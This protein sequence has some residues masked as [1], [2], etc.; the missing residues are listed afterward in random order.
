MSQTSL[1]GCRRGLVRPCHGRSRA[2]D[3]APP[4][5]ARGHGEGGPAEGGSR[6]RDPRLQAAPLLRDFPARPGV[7]PRP[8]M[9]SRI[10]A[11]A[12]AWAMPRHWVTWEGVHRGAGPGRC[13]GRDHQT[14]VQLSAG[15]ALPQGFLRPPHGRE[16]RGPRARGRGGLGPEGPLTIAESGPLGPRGYAARSVPL[17]GRR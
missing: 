7:R 12:Q 9:L 3:G 17:Y 1:G 4:R 16:A 10:T 15:L 13:R 6:E 11:P 14:R 2:P 8:R 5:R